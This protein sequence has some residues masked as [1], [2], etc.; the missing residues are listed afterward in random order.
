MIFKFLIVG[1][2]NT[3][4]GYSIIYGLYYLLDI[5][6]YV[7]TFFGYAA[8]FLISMILNIKNTFDASLSYINVLLYVIAFL[9]ALLANW[10][11]MYFMMSMARHGFMF[12]Q[13][14]S[15]I[16]YIG[17]FFVVAKKLIATRNG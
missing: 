2:F 12:S 4:V 3:A 7:S 1:I 10:L 11:V 16:V 14:V 17:L 13:V 8:G 6:E 15:S 5:N 9:T